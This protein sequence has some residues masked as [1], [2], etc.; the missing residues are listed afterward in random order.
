MASF[1]TLPD[2]MLLHIIKALFHGAEINITK[3]REDSL[4]L[5]QPDRPNLLRVTAVNHHLRSL[6][7]GAIS[8]LAAFHLSGPDS[9]GIKQYHA[10]LQAAP[11]LLFV[12]SIEIIPKHGNLHLHLLNRP[13]RT[14]MPAIFST[15]FPQLSKITMKSEASD[16]YGLISKPSGDCAGMERYSQETKFV[17]AMIKKITNCECSRLGNFLQHDACGMF[18]RRVELTFTQGGKLVSTLLSFVIRR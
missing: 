3:P 1:I 11:P 12:A 15:T 16:L 18:E 7:M 13:R 10:F 4:Q 5:A 8:E 6:V 14:E 9:W 2:E 17:D